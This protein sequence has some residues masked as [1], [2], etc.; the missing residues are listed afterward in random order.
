E[1]LNIPDMVDMLFHV[2]RPGSDG[3]NKKIIGGQNCN[4]TERLYHV[5]LEGDNGTHMSLCGGSLIHPEWI[6]TAA[7]CWKSE[8]TTAKLGVHPR[9][10]TQQ[11]QIIQHN[12]VIYVNKWHYQHDIM[13][14]KLQRPVRN[15]RPVRLPRCNN[16]ITISGVL[17]QRHV[18]TPVSVDEILHGFIFC[19]FI[20]PPNYSF[21]TLSS[22]LTFILIGDSGGGVVFNK[23]IVGVISSRGKNFV[24][25]NPIFNMDV[26]DYLEWIR[27][28]TGLNKPKIS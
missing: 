4:D 26:C 12:P 10:A 14:L 11:K 2:L 24:F 28:T 17:D 25:R 13:L 20:V 22:F 16:R 9:T 5:R 7:H 6:L 19:S 21:S 8:T 23:K 18:D 15:I 1:G 27:N 3:R